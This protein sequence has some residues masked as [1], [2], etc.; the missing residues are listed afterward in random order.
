[1]ASLPYSNKHTFII[2]FEKNT[3]NNNELGSDSMSV[4]KI[5]FMTMFFIS[6]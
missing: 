1:M 3:N 2:T 6:N 4:I 5:Y